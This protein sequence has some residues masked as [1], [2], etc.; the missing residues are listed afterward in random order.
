MYVITAGTFDML[1][2][3][4]LNLL[5]NCRTLA[6]PDGV[7]EVMVNTD[8][9]VK[10]FKGKRP[11]QDFF[12]R[13]RVVAQLRDVSEDRAYGHN[14]HADLPKRLVELRNSLPYG[15]PIIL[16]VGSDWAKKNYYKQIGIDQANLDQLK[17]TLVY[18]PYTEGISSTSL[19]ERL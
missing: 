9:F 14:D 10:K 3:G 4:H 12:T 1:H 15:S 8:S 17:I 7:V 5:K 2:L 19:R 13:A 6:G 11:V 16:V 18:I